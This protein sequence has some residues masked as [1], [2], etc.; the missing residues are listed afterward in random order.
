MVERWRLLDRNRLEYQATVEDPKVLTG[1]WTTQRIVLK[2]TSVRKIAE[3]HCI[4]KGVD[5]ESPALN[6]PAAK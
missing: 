3:G 5:W 4:P 1:P 2:R 6:P